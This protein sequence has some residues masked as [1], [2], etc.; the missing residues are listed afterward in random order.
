[1]ATVVALAAN[2]WTDLYAAT[3]IAVGTRI[4][5]ENIGSAD[6]HLAT[7]ASQPSAATNTVT[8]GHELA[9]GIVAGATSGASTSADLENA[10][11]LGAAIDGTVDEIVLCVKSYSGT[12]GFDG[13]LGWRELT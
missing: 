3:G 5:V 8:G 7:Q 10:L 9:G 6:I 4:L 1:M 13:S 11:R 2:T 12:G